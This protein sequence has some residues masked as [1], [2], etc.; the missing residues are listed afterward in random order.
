MSIT[1]VSED[2]A[3]ALRGALIDGD[4]EQAMHA[5]REALSAGA[6]PLVLIHQVLVPTLSEIGRR[7]EKLELYLP[8]LMAAGAAGRASSELIE[9]ELIKHGSNASSSG[10]VVIGTVKGDIHDIGKNIVATIFKAHAYKVVDLGKDVSALQFIEAA[11]ANH[12]DV[13]AT[14]AL[15]SITRAGCRDVVDLL[16]E[17]SVRD[18]Y[19][20]IIGGGSVD[21]TYAT[22]IGADAY[23]GTAAGA[24][25][26]VTS[27]LNE[28]RPANVLQ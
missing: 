10:V 16:K 24:V 8:E 1:A 4:P 12:A 11:E 21:Q 25:E 20:C 26:A 19:F 9:A 2:H 28:R 18:K 17:L 15:M 14:S 3:K 27:Y 23:A 22:Q 7:F 6:D 13:I 5:T